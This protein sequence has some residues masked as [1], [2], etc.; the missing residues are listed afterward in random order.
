LVSRKVVTVLVS[1]ELDVF[2]NE[3][4]VEAVVELD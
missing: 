4:G 2:G 1:E 3:V